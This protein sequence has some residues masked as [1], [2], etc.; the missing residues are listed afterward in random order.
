MSGSFQDDLGFVGNKILTGSTVSGSEAVLY[1]EGDEI[2][3]GKT[4]GDVKTPAVAASINIADA[5]HALAGGLAA[6]SQDIATAVQVINWGMPNGN[7]NVIATIG[8]SD[9]A[10]IYAYEV[11]VGMGGGIDAAGRRVHLHTTTDG[12]ATATT[13]GSSL[14]SAAV[15][16]VMEFDILASGGDLDLVE[17][18]SLVLDGRAV[19]ENI[20]VQWYKDGV[21]IEGGASLDLGVLEQ[22][23]AGT[24]TV[25]AT[26]PDAPWVK[27]FKE[28]SYIVSVSKRGPEAVLVTS[29]SDLTASD[30]IIKS[31]LEG[32]GYYVIQSDAADTYATDVEGKML[33]VIS[34]SAAASG[35]IVF[36]NTGSTT[37]AFFATTKEF[38]D[39]VELGLNNRLIDSLSFEYF[40]DF[41]AD[42]DE[43]AIARIYANDGDST[44]AANKPGTLLYESDS[45]TIAPGFNSVVIGGLLLE[46]TDSITWTVDFNGVGDVEG[47]RAGLIFYNPPS[48]GSSDDDF[49]VNNT[50]SREVIYSNN[51]GSVYEA[52]YK[53]GSEFGDQIRLSSTSAMS[54]LSFE[55]YAE[56]SNAPSEATAKL[57]IYANDGD[58]YLTT[59]TKQPGTLLFESGSIA[60]KEG[61]HTYTVSDIDAVLPRDIT[62]TVEFGGVTGDELTVGN[63]AALILAGI[64]GIGTSNADFWQKTGATWTTYVTNDA[65]DVND[66]SAN[67]VKY[68]A[69]SGGWSTYTVANAEIVNNF[70]AKVTAGVEDDLLTAANV[71]MIVLSSGFQS[72]VRYTGTGEVDSGTASGSK[73]TVVNADHG[74]AGGLSGDVGLVTLGNGDAEIGWGVPQGDVEIVATLVGDGEKAAIYGYQEGAVLAD[75]N[76]APERRSFVFATDELL[77]K[78]DA[79]ALKL[80]DSAIDWTGGTGFLTSPSSAELLEG[81]TVT[82]SAEGYGPG[83]VTY[84]WKKNGSNIDGATGTS[85]ILES[86]A[87]DAAANYSVVVTSASGATAEAT[88]SVNVYNLP[89]ITLVAPLEG[90][91]TSAVTHQVKIRAVGGADRIDV[92]TISIAINGVD[93]T[94]NMNLASN[95]RGVQVTADLVENTNTDTI[96]GVFL[97]YEDL[98]PGENNG[99]QVTMSFEVIGGA[100]VLTKQWSYTLYDSS[101]TGGDGSITKMAVNQIF[102]RGNDLYVVWP[103]SPGLMLERNSDCKG[104]VWEPL[105]NTVGRGLHVEPNCGTQAFFRLVR[106]KE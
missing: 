13:A 106:V 89:A 42:G 96:K 74:L 25:K 68:S 84:Q 9:K 94:E 49:W 70:G 3:E 62:W 78:A 16:W 50:N 37:G 47:N 11:G 86:V 64:D 7:A 65:N 28:I 40:G 32:K 82:L 10:A 56:I 98:A 24:Y 75:G 21:A 81:E 8:D 53:S 93:V 63:N 104:G 85:L 38:G 52:Y 30:A 83:D 22:G 80:I 44:G 103:G 55:A 34:P 27:R 46:A 51:H 20:V 15:N 92:E 69:G 73:I 14:I 99:M 61:Y 41:T 102:Q 18:E 88:A 5:S 54:E 71:P 66:F 36:N 4:V 100:R 2:P 26:D 6:G 76:A 97:G 90:S 91:T 33:V 59:D 23:D 101:Q 58:T 31:K 79:N 1:V 57:R 72:H 17:G 87:K 77:G 19:G 105:P 67:V 39:Q 43:T 35:E 12:L 60:L 29:S 48:V 45:F 95:I